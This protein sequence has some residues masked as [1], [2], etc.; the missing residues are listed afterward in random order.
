MRACAYQI[1]CFMDMGL[2]DF[3]KSA[4][5]FKVKTRERTLAEGEIL[6]NDETV[7]HASKKKKRRVVFD[8]LPAKR[9]RTD[10]AV[11]SEPVPTTGGKSPPALKR[12]ELQ[13]KP[14]GV[15]SKSIPPIA[16]EFVSSSVTP[17]HELDIH[18][19]SGFTQDVGVRTH[20][21]SMGIVVS[22]SSG[23][24]DGGASPR[25][26]PHV[27]VGGIAAASTQGVGASGNSTEASTSVHDADSPA[28]D[29]FNSQTIETATAENI[30][31]LKG[32]VT[33]GARHDAKIAALKTKLEKAEHEVAEV[34]AL[35]CC[36]SEL[37]AG[38]VAKSEELLT[39]EDKLREEFKSF[40][41]AKACRFEEKY[42]ELDARIAEVRRDMDN[43]LSALGKV[44]Y[45][46]INKGIQ[47]SLE[48]GIEHGKSGR[49]LA[50]VEAYDPGVKDE[51]V[52]AVADFEN[53]SFSL[54]DELESIKDSPLASIMCAL[55]LKDSQAADRRGLRLPFGSTL[56]EASGSAPPYN[57]TLGVADY[58]V[59]TLVLYGDGGSANQ[60][61]VVQPHD[62]LF[63]TSV[64]EGSS[65][66]SFFDSNVFSFVV[67]E[68]ILTMVLRITNY[69]VK[70][71]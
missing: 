68:P 59:S 60:P 7:K 27:R 19:D 8:D 10:A 61:L 13:S 26:E 31:V 42:A 14:Q 28:D 39:G 62:D 46:A 71:F 30:Y 16:K 48:A 37:E 41:N 6:L 22:F 5:P 64:L 4:D 65:G 38:V 23:P 51:F 3:V 33:N 9:L 18:E 50:Q 63:D 25:V 1:F 57:L 17:T 35:C 29:F 43:D 54:L 34:V 53:V 24:D 40:Q 11:A 32:N 36:V 66:I 20:H 52:A 12:L 70:L 55:V 21:A 45:L 67:F 47:E 44:I 2:L 56:G 15:G 69:L 58:Q 49:S